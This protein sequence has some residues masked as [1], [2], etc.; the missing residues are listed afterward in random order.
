MHEHEEYSGGAGDVEVLLI[1]QIFKGSADN[2]RENP[3]YLLASFRFYFSSVQAT[4]LEAL[5]QWTFSILLGH[6]F[7]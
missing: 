1:L 3:K 4:G 2:F 5:N 6:H 7:F